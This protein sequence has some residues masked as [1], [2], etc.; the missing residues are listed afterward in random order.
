MSTSVRVKRRALE[1]SGSGHRGSSAGKRQAATERK[2]AGTTAER[3]ETV[4]L[5]A[6]EFERLTKAEAEAFLAAR[7]C[8]LTEAGWPPT[9]ALALAKR[10][11]IDLE[12]ARSYGATYAS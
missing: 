3:P 4:T 12:D 11:E 8:S 10:T 9:G 2:E 7:Y 5:R 1:S 6:D